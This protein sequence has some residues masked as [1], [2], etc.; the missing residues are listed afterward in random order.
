MEFDEIIDN[1]WKKDE[2]YY[3]KHNK[4]DHSYYFWILLIMNLVDI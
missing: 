2:N 1:D 3:N 4:N